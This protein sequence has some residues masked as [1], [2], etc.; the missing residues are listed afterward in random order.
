MRSAF[1]SQTESFNFL[2]HAVSQ[3]L[4]NA[5]TSRFLAHLNHLACIEHRVRIGENSTQV[6][7]LIAAYV[8]EILPVESTLATQYDIA[9]L[10]TNLHR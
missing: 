4:A 7:K 9:T 6:R 10:S 2:Y 8:L 1:N 3:Q 5:R